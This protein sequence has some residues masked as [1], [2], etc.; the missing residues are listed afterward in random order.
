MLCSR[1]FLSRPLGFLCSRP[2]WYNSFE[3]NWFPFR[4]RIWD[5]NWLPEYLKDPRLIKMAFKVFILFENFL[6][7]HLWRSRFAW[8]VLLCGLSVWIRS[9]F[10][11]EWSSANSFVFL[12]L[13]TQIFGLHGFC[14]G[15]IWTGFYPT[16]EI[17]IIFGF[18]VGFKLL[19]NPDY[20]EHPIILCCFH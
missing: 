10:H 19:Q 11:W 13:N 7:S 12:W 16:C 6:L 9:F 18:V 20:H 8:Y 14:L 1:V 2:T 4:D 3:S 17:G 5:F 15:S